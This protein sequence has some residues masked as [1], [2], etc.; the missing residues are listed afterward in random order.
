M[1]DSQISHYRLHPGVLNSYISSSAGRNGRLDI[2]TR[3]LY[4]NDL[5]LIGSD[6][7]YF[8]KIVKE[9][10]NPF[11]PLRN[12][13][14]ECVNKNTLSKLPDFWY[15]KLKIMN[16]LHDDFSMFALTCN[17]IIETEVKDSKC[18]RYF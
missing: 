8:S 11:S 7:T 12:L 10:G 4:E 18:F 3:K 5:L 16:A 15:E 17:K 14:I 9:N 1:I 2:S 6:G 13:I